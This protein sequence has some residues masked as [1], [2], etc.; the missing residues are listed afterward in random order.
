ME[1]GVLGLTGIF[2]DAARRQSYG[3]WTL[4][5]RL[6]YGGISLPKDRR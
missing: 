2:L 5:D 6:I 4:P 1:I 3:S